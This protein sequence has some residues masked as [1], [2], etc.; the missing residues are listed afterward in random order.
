[1]RGMAAQRLASYPPDLAVATGEIGAGASRL[2]AQ[3]DDRF[4]GCSAAGW[5][6]R[7]QQGDQ[8]G[9]DCHRGGGHGIAVADR[10]ELATQGFAEQQPDPEADYQADKH[11][12]DPISE[13][14]PQDI[15]PLRT[16]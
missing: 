9:Q 14:H 5:N 4:R 7:R 15:A 11:Q 2:G 16:Q 1:M 13:N 10:I 6:P 12:S 8:E 3:C